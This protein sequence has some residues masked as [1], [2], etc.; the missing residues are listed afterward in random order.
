MFYDED[1]H[2]I[3]QFLALR[4]SL[5]PHVFH[6]RNNPVKDD[7]GMSITSRKKNKKQTDAIL[8]KVGT[9]MG[10]F[11]DNKE[12]SDVKL[13]VGE[14]VFEAHKIVLVSASDVFETMLMKGDW[15]EAS[16]QE[17]ELQED[18][19]DVFALVLKFLYTG[20][21]RL[22]IE[23]LMSIYT[24]ADKYNL[25]G[26]KLGLCKFLHKFVSQRQQQGK[27]TAPEA[28]AVCNAFEADTLMHPGL[29]CIIQWIGSNFASFI[30]S[31]EWQKLP[32]RTIVMLLQKDEI[33]DNEQKIFAAAKKWLEF[34]STRTQTPELIYEILQHIRLTHISAREL[35]AIENDPIVVR[36]PQMIKLVSETIRRKFYDGVPNFIGES[37]KPRWLKRRDRSYNT[38]TTAHAVRSSFDID[39]YYDDYDDGDVYDWS[40]SDGY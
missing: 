26:L 10:R 20:K 7:T 36:C 27:L 38:S 6:E 18:N 30:K 31:S 29:K 35:Y 11:F 14:R 1:D 28:I 3:L 15:Q 13:K 4:Q 21:I 25:K 24:I 2:S 32:R 33:G 8:I 5:Q 39:D 40:S 34:D 23:N 17:I 37:V 9:S 12:L 16:Q 22:H 19:S